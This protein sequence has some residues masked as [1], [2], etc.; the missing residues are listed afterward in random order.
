M[1]TKKEKKVSHQCLLFAI[2]D[3]TGNLGINKESINDNNFMF[4][5]NNN[6]VHSLAL[7]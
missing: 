2:S 5:N 4:N 3:C 1:N 6:I 7:E